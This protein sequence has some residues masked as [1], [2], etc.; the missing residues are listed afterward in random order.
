MGGQ[1]KETLSLQL[2]MSEALVKLP[3]CLVSLSVK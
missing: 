3:L 1:W 2:I